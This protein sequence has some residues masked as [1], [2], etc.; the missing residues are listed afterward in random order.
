MSRLIHQQLMNGNVQLEKPRESFDKHLKK[1]C[2][3]TT[4]LAEGG[5]AVSPGTAPGFMDGCA[6]LPSTLSMCS[7][8]ISRLCIQAAM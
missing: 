8:R 2:N 4:D 5:H 7:N 6:D 1:K 3:Q